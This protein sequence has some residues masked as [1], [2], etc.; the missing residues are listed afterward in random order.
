VIVNV[1]L[2]E[3]AYDVHIEPGLLAHAGE[4][5]A[6]LTGRKRIAVISDSTVTRLYLESLSAALGQAGLTVEPI[7]VP[8]GEATKNWR[9]L[10]TVVESLLGF[11]VERG[12][13]VVA[14]GGGVV[15]DLTGFA[16][17]I[18]R[19][20]CRF[21]QI[22]TT[23]LAQVD[24]SVGGKT[25]IN[26]RAGKNLVGAFHQPAAVLIDPD[27]LDTLPARELRAGYA[28]VVKTALLGDA[29]FFD[30][31]DANVAALLAGDTA[32]RTHAIATS[33]AAKATIVAADE[34]E[35]GDTRALLNLGHTF[36]HALEAEAGFSDRLLHG[37]AVAI[38]CALAFRFSAERGLCPPADAAR[39][40]DHLAR[41]G[42]PN[43][44]RGIAVTAAP[45][46]AH[47]LQDKK[48][49]S[50]TLPFV[51]AHGIGHAFVARDVALA[52]VAAFLDRVLAEG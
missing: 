47:M 34:R 9:T 43:H 26:A 8:P 42:L 14:L 21:V 28:E 45:L 12:D 40:A 37:E 29:A 38:G 36:G 25:A 50:G 33:V 15:G 16:A 51:L 39:V 5:I 11:G 32:A 20:G 23:L 27:L 6:P 31:C 10:E 44:P 18:L 1:P 17:A 48:M 19:R 30:W 24:S 35:T 7:V 4:I 2:G 22:P 13:V 46:L 49:R 41:A 52:D 3:R